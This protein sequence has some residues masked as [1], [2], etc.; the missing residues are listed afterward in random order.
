MILFVCNQGKY[1]SKTAA[2]LFKAEYAGIYSEEKPLTAELLQ[3]AS[4]VYVFEESQ[5]RFIADH[6]PKEYLSKQIINLE[7]EDIYGFKD[8][9]LIKILKR[10]VKL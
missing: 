2:W 4:V 1:R 6:F 7:I 5:R 9:R 3:R 10:K 8:E